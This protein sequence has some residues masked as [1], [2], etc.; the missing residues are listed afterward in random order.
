MSIHLR[1]MDINAD[2]PRIVQIINTFI[3]DPTSVQQMQEDEANAPAART[4]HRMNAVNAGG[5]ILGYNWVNRSPWMPDGHFWFR[6]TVD[7]VYRKAGIGSLLFEDGLTFAESCGGTRLATSVRDDDDDSLHFVE[8]RSFRVDR[9]IFDSIL[10]VSAFDE[11][12]FAGI[13]DTAQAS[14]IRFTTLAEAGNT[15][16]NQRRI[17][18]L[19]TR[20]T[21]DV[22]GEPKPMPPFEEYRKF[23]FS[24]SLF[25]SDGIFIAV[26][27]E[28]WVGFAGLEYTKET[29]L[30]V[31]TMTGVDR[32]YRGR[33]IALALKLL[34]IRCA[35]NYGAATIRTN[36]DSENAPMLAINR[37]LGYQPVPGYYMVIRELQ[38]QIDR[39]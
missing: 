21:L 25:I 3:P 32:E 27:G 11:S 5:L 29:N 16:E 20:L 12:H 10:D 22:P 9:H 34:A 28:R 23:A 15:E 39:P 6:V 1:P 13:I 24:G 17:Y 37:K 38:L 35:R 7:R 4:I 26:D 18:D 14:G 31:N 19:D 36:N 2:L 30:M 33:H 8:H